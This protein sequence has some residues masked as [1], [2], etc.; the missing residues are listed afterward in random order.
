M[1][2]VD[3]TTVWRPKSQH[4]DSCFLEHSHTIL[5]HHITQNYYSIRY[6]FHSEKYKTG[7]SDCPIGNSL[8]GHK[9]NIVF[10][11]ER[12]FAFVEANCW[13]RARK[14]RYIFAKL[15]EVR[16]DGGSYG[17]HFPESL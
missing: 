17:A 10:A 11:F 8:L 13:K 16:M 15:N 3:E 4:K 7:I 2:D 12:H 1:H 6:N 9:I 14:F 5:E